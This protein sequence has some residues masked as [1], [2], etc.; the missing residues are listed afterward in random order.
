MSEFGRIM[1]YISEG[2]G[3]FD[4]IFF[5]SIFVYI[6]MWFCVLIVCFYRCFKGKSIFLI[7]EAD[8]LQPDEDELSISE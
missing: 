6:F 8:D 1:T 4:S 3:F 7:N 2:M 5:Y